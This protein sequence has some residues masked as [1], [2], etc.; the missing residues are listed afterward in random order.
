MRDADVIGFD[1]LNSRG[2]DAELGAASAGGGGETVSVSGPPGLFFGAAFAR[3]EFCA[4]L[5]LVS[6]PIFVNLDSMDVIAPNFSD[7]RPKSAIN[8]APD[9][10]TKRATA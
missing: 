6:P 8:G 5:P 9:S 3:V 10:G 7:R 2:V 4:E 1:L